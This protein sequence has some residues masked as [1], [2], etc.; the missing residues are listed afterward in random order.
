MCIMGNEGKARKDSK[1]CK[2]R[3]MRECAKANVTVSEDYHEMN[4][5]Q[6]IQEE[7]TEK[8]YED[9]LKRIRIARRSGDVQQEEFIQLVNDAIGLRSM[10]KF[11]TEIG[12]NTSSISR[13]LSGKV[14]EVSSEL[15]AKI[16]AYSDSESGVTLEKLMLAQGLS[17]PAL[18]Y[19]K[20]MTREQD[21][22]QVVVEG[23]CAYGYT[24]GKLKETQLKDV[25][26]K[27]KE[28]VIT[29]NAI[30]KG[31]GWWH[32][33]LDCFNEKSKMLADHFDRWLQYSMSRYYCGET[34]IGRFTRMFDDRERFERAK[35][36]IA[37]Y[38]ISDEI[39]IMLISPEERRVIEEYIIPLRDGSTPKSVFI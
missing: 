22:I 2:E 7:C 9:Y 4:T 6:L 39:S 10:S 38:I 16:A 1:V 23:L 37:D 25:F 30:S 13:I 17:T 12:V 35:S 27:K 31:A 14:L 19:N 21:Y 33:S 32:L 34:K 24:A 15:L 26:T 11:A 3:K 5:Q 28:K 8:K 20:M 29:T 36:R 18:N